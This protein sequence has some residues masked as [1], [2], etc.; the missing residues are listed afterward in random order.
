PKPPTRGQ[1]GGR[2]QLVRLTRPHGGGRRQTALKR[3]Q[4]RDEP[5]RCR[6]AASAFPGR[7]HGFVSRPSELWCPGSL[8]HGTVPAVGGLGETPPLPPSSPPPPSPEANRPEGWRR[9]RFFL[10]T[11]CRRGYTEARRSS[12]EAEGAWP[13]QE[14]TA[15]LQGYLERALTGDAEARQRL[16]ELTRDRLMGH[17]SRLLHGHFARLEPFAQTDDVVQQLYVKILR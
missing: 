1:G 16:L 12:P 9:R 5:A 4:V 10:N 14:S 3:L 11:S 15:V 13:V 2:Q 7:K 6:G 8:P 17:A